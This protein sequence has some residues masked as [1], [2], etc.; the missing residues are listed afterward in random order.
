MSIDLLHYKNASRMAPHTHTHARNTCKHHMH[1]VHAVQQLLTIPVVAL[2]ITNSS[3]SI[4]RLTSLQP[5]EHISVIREKER[6]GIDE[7]K[8]GER[9]REG[10]RGRGRR[11]RKE[12]DYYISSS[13]SVC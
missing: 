1:Y 7:D 9:E 10:G 6:R 4:Q 8:T 5:M 13:C 12:R 2:L 11:E 3:T